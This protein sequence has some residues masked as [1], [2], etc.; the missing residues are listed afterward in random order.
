MVSQSNSI[1]T[2]DSIAAAFHAQLPPAQSA[3]LAEEVG[4]AAR[5]I[6]KLAPQQR[7][8]SQ[9]MAILNAP[10]LGL[11]REA[12]RGHEHACARSL[13]SIGNGAQLGDLQFGDLVGRDQIGQQI[14]INLWAWERM[15]PQV[16]HWID[17]QI[18]RQT[19][20]SAAEREALRLQQHTEWAQAHWDVAAQRYRLEMQRLHG[21]MQIFGMRRPMPLADVFTDVYMLD[22]PSAWRRHSIEELQKRAPLPNHDDRH[23]ERLSGDA[24]VANEP[25]LFLLGQPGAGKT[26][27]LKHLV[28][29]AVQGQINAI[30]IFVGLKAW[31]DSKLELM[32]FLVRQ[33]AICNFPN[34]QPFIET[35]LDEGNALVL[36]DGL[37][38]VSAVQDLRQRIT[39]MIREFAQQYGH[40]RMVITCRTAA[41]DYLF[42]QFRYCELADFSQAQ[43]EEFVGRWFAES[44]AK[45]I[46][47]LDAFS[48]PEHQRLGELA[49][50]PL[51]L[52]MLC[53][54]FDETM[55][56]P[57]RKAELYEEAL[58]ALLKKWDS[59]RSIQ[60]DQIYKQ[61]SLGHKRQ[62]LTELAAEC[63]ARGEFLMHKREL[64]QRVSQFLQRLPPSDHRDEVDGE[65]VLRS[66][67]AQHGLLIERAQG[68]YS[69]SH[70]TFQEYFTAR[71]IATHSRNEVRQRALMQGAN[72]QWR[73]VLHLT[74]SMLD[75]ESAGI[76]FR[77]WCKYLQRLISSDPALAEM[78]TWVAQQAAHTARPSASLRAA[79]LNIVWIDQAALLNQQII[80]ILEEISAG[81]PTLE[82][83]RD[84]TRD[85]GRTR[86][87]ARMLPR[88][89]DV[90]RAHGLA[91]ALTRSRALARARDLSLASTSVQI[92]EYCAR[93][94]Q[95]RPFV[96]LDHV[97]QHNWQFTKRQLELIEA[98]LNSTQCLIECLELASVD[99]RQAVLDQLLLPAQV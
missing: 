31:A 1:D 21:S 88:S 83:A 59:S 81:D 14:T 99:N 27:F 48:R 84:I 49:R 98:Y 92:Y 36:F 77:L 42:E 54:T 86:A 33:F 74:A 80:M 62:L 68:I 95:D 3:A 5:A 13:I 25:C 39:Q 69:F 96:N 6:A 90:A 46:A 34:A 10:K 66:I 63:F 30:P 4:L 72:P 17:Q 23:T 32:P 20:L 93:N 22:K 91:R 47:F 57:Q 44:S 8:L 53:L 40:S 76:F 11:L 43:I 58:D 67:E 35:I 65:V 71:Y 2:I 24:V 15:Q 50:R 38:E 70:L 12:L 28:M 64:A 19:E 16:L 51:L 29:E 9:L 7:G 41:S 37:D 97:P 60:R 18:N 89:R 55:A 45:R 78:I 85:L 52:T 94:E 75:Y 56:F 26:T 61:L 79:V 82:L 87:L 73:E